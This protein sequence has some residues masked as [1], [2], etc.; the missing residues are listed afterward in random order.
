LTG[1]G[2]VAVWNTADGSLAGTLGGLDEMPQGLAFS[3]DGALVATGQK[4]A[5]VLWDW[6]ANTS[7]RVPL[8]EGAQ[9]TALRFSPDGKRLAV[10]TIGPLA[11]AETGVRVWDLGANRVVAEWSGARQRVTHLAFSP[12]GRRLATAAGSWATLSQ[13][14]LLKLWDADAGREVFSAELSPGA[15]TAVAFSPDGRRLAAATQVSDV[16][17]ILSGGKV[18]GDIYVWD[19]TPP[20]AG[21][22]EP[23]R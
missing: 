8:A 9:V 16:S 1:K 3:P 10:A 14:G 23:S 5:V 12:D 11:P 13:Q 17:A 19:A 18:P 7:R 22:P 4:G 6:K 15:V 2:E 21:R 20:D